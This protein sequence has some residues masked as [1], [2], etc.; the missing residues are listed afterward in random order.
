MGA[1]FLRQWPSVSVT[2]QGLATD[3]HYAL[4]ACGFGRSGHW[5]ATWPLPAAPGAAA[6][7]DAGFGTWKEIQPSGLTDTAGDK[8]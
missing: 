2:N 4:A 7:S 8:E 5:L 6:L 1:E 3:T